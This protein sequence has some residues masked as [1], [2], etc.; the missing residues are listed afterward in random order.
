MMPNKR[1]VLYVAVIVVA[2]VFISGC[3]NR[4][5]LNEMSVEDAFRHLEELYND[6]KYRLAIEGLDFFTLNYSGHSR[7]DSAQ[8]LLG[9]SYF[10]TKEFLLSANAFD[11]L[12]NRFPNSGLVPDAM[13]M[14][15]VC[16]KELSPRYTLDQHYTE[17][18]IRSLQLFIDYF[19][20]YKDRVNEAQ[21]HIETCRDKLA[22]KVYSTGVIYLKMKDYKAASIYFLAVTEEYYDTQWAGKAMFQYGYSLYQKKEYEQAAEVL[23]AFIDKYIDHPWQDQAG[24]LLDDAITQRDENPDDD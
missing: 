1:I 10:H 20:D 24:V 22:Q 17:Q 3:S 7:V 6:G 2:A 8:Y 12:V 11:E 16:Y 13:F 14:V 9:M 21:Q 23:Q 19:P 4:P 5:T 18:A 15:G